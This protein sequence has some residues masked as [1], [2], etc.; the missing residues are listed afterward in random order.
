M[1]KTLAIIKTDNAPAAIGPY[2]QAIVSNALVFTSGQIAIDSATNKLV[3]GSIEEQTKQVLENLSNILIAA[4][5]SLQK[6]VKVTVYLENMD[7][8]TKMNEVYQKYFIHKPARST[9]QAAKLPKNAKIEID[10]IAEVS[11]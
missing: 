7:D 2:S 11:K 6:A 5:S 4:G 3:D 10:V 9:I 8:F 1:S